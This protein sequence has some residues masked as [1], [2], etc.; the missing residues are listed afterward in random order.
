MGLGWSSE[1]WDPNS[2]WRLGTAPGSG[3]DG[4]AKMTQAAEGPLWTESLSPGL[5]CSGLQSRLP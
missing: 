5:E 3:G 4:K 2:F 1:A